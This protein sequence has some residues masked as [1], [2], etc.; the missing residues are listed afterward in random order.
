MERR[1]REGRIRREEIGRERG[2]RP[3]D[4]RWEDDGGWEKYEWYTDVNF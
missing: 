1:E 3:E 2:E 4:G